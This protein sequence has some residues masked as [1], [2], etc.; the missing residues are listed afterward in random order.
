LRVCVKSASRETLANCNEKLSQ[1]S[2]AAAPTANL[3]Q[4]LSFKL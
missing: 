1:L 3:Q 2:I 4:T